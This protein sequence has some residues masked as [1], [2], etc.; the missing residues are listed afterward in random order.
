[1]KMSGSEND[2]EIFALRTR[3]LYSVFFYQCKETLF[4]RADYTYYSSSSLLMHKFVFICCM[5]NGD[6]LTTVMGLL[7]YI[8]KYTKSGLQYKV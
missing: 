5:E 4:R 2:L 8:Q 7:K 6:I 3:G 1:M